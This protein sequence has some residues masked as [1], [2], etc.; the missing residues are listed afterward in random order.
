VS[1][2]ERLWVRIRALPLP[3]VVLALENGVVEEVIDDLSGGGA[4]ARYVA[5]RIELVDDV[6]GYW[7][8]ARRWDAIVEERGMR[9]RVMMG[10]LSS[11]KSPWRIK[12]VGTLER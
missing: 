6:L 4:L 5:C 2:S 1:L 8:D 7:I 9:Q 12:S 11:E 3:V 10:L